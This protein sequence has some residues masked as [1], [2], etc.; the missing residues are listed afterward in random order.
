MFTI[1]KHKWIKDGKLRLIFHK[2][3]PKGE[4]INAITPRH[5][6]ASYFPEGTF[7]YLTLA[8]ILAVITKAGRGCLIIT[9]DAKDAYKQLFVRPAD[10]HQQVFKAGGKFFVDL[11]A[12][13]GALYGNDS[14]SAFA[15]VHC[16][17][18][19]NATDTVGWLFH[20]VDNYI[21][22]IPNTGKTTSLRAQLS[23]TCLKREVA[24]SGLLTHEWTGPTHKVT[25]IGWE[26][27]TSI[28]TVSITSE[29]KKLMI[30]LLQSWGTKVTASVSELSSL[31]GLLIFLAQI[32]GGI[33]AT[34]GVLIL[35]RTTLN[36]AS[37]TNF[38]VSERVRAAVTHIA[39][40]LE[41]WHGHAMIFD[42]CWFNSKADLTVY[43]DIA[44]DKTPEVGSFG[45]GAFCIPYSLW[46]SETWTSEELEGA[47]RKTAHS[48]AHLELINML[49]AVLRF[50]TTTQKVLCY[51]DNKA[52]VAIARARYSE[53]ANS[54]IEER[55]RR[56]DVACCERNLVVRF[57]WQSRDFPLPKLADELSRGK[58][59]P[60]SPCG[61][62]YSFLLFH[63]VE[64]V[65]HLLCVCRCK[66][67]SGKKS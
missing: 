1:P 17:C 65:I 37:R 16:V 29:R 59:A 66:R 23:F 44:K 6:A 40:V 61:F 35:Q 46:F 50:A 38:I 31:I 8:K 41:R 36:R 14:Y 63:L 21:L 52:A 2:S 3:F 30:S 15:Y 54:D 62:R 10:L 67:R 13:F 5:D 39:Y 28:F 18:L 43:C 42:R 22:I 19:A 64:Q 9:F 47:M 55:L 32:V 4:S 34:I 20:Y 56:F 33:K 12:S 53:T 25:F 45:K 58:V 51:C 57:R 11:C 24:R 49:D 7:F 60:L 27:D 26:I 48:T